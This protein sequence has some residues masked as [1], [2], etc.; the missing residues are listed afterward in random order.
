VN[1]RENP[2]QC[3]EMAVVVAERLRDDDPGWLSI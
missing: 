1:V 3:F 2:R